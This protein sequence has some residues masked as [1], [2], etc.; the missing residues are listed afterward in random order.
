MI[1]IHDKRADRSLAPSWL[2]GARELQ[3][4]ESDGESWWG[5]GSGYLCGPQP[6]VKWEKLPGRLSVA[7]I[8][9]IDP[10]DLVTDQ[11]WITTE[12]IA[13]LSLR[14]WFAPCVLDKDGSR[15]FR[16]AYGPD[17]LPALTPVQERCEAIANAARSALIA[18][19]CD[20]AP[21]PIKQ[22]C[23]WAAELLSAVNHITPDII[24]ALRL[25]DDALIGGVLYR[26][27]GLPSTDA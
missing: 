8:G 9:T 14:I 6:T 17:F 13:D 1:L 16:T 7:A 18:A 24:G 12:P 5:I 23:A 22:A 10:R 11:R 2:E 26:A 20:D 4:R 21:I 3:R 25:L 19:H 27:A 15:R